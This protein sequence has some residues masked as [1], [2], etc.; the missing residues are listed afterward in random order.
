LD[1]I[2]LLALPLAIASTLTLTDLSSVGLGDKNYL[3]KGDSKG[4]R[5]YHFFLKVPTPVDIYGTTKTGKGS[6]LE[7]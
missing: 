2:H 3:D 7:K 5:S 6:G 1:F 4:Y